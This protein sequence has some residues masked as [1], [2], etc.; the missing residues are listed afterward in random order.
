MK[1][2]IVSLVGS[3]DLTK[4]LA[5][6]SL[7][8]T[9]PF[10]PDLGLALGFKER[11]QEALRR[12]IEQ[13]ADL[14]RRDSGLPPSVTAVLTENLQTAFGTRFVALLSRWFYEVLFP[15]S[16][17]TLGLY[18]VVF[19]AW[20]GRLTKRNEDAFEFGVE[21]TNLLQKFDAI[22][23]MKDLGERI[24]QAR[25]KPLSKWDE[26]VYFLMG[27]SN[28][29]ALVERVNQ[30]WDESLGGSLL[31]DPFAVIGRAAERQTFIVFWDYM[32]SVAKEQNLQ[33]IKSIAEEYWGR[34]LAEPASIGSQIVWETANGTDLP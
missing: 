12:E 30:V 33:R 2:Q 6:I 8:N 24:A 19:H 34:S 15:A 14:F 27:F 18:E 3:I 32:L 7:D 20:Y 23:R 26:A 4:G 17:D 13:H 29:S 10:F 21:Q 1:S 16:G 11:F 5:L 25:L 31:S 28:D 22:I 9:R